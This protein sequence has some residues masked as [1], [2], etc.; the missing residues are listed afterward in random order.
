MA[1][2]EHRKQAQ[3]EQERN[4]LNKRLANANALAS[5]TEDMG[6]DS[7]VTLHHQGKQLERIDEDLHETEQTL[8]KSNHVLSGMKS[9]TRS[10]GNYLFGSKP[11][12]KEYS[13]PE[14]NRVKTYRTKKVAKKRVDPSTIL[15][16]EGWLNK[17]GAKVPYGWKKRW[18]VLKKN[19]EFMYYE[20]QEEK[21]LKGTAIFLP[22][23]KIHCYPDDP[24]KFDV[25]DEQGRTWYLESED[26]NKRADWCFAIK[27]PEQYLDKLNADND[28]GEPSPVLD[29]DEGIDQLLQTA[30][31]L[32]QI[33]QDQ[34][35]ELDYHNTL[36]NS[37]DER[38]E[39]VNNKAKGQTRDIEKL[40]K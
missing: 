14:D 23:S 15:V 8:D 39:R 32:H 9:I 30:K 6:A 40:I 37:V 35:T 26:E 19:G 12:R 2:E 18:C 25:K 22:T 38:M 31:R 10:V 33:A 28:D 11:E 1:M 34:N 20:N 4:D 16:K 24:Q 3:L 29:Y 36:L 17:K 5:Q 7:L 27:D 21:D 13:A